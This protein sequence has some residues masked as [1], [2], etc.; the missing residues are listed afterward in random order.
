MSS[1]KIDFFAKIKYAIH[2]KD[3]Q[4]VLVDIN[5]AKIRT[6]LTLEVTSLQFQLKKPI[7]K[8]KKLELVKQTQRR[9]AQLEAM[10]DTNAK[11]IDYS[12]EGEPTHGHQLMRAE[13]LT[14]EEVSYTPG[15]LRTSR[16]ETTSRT[17]TETTE[18]KTFAAAKRE[19]DEIKGSIDST[20]DGNKVTDDGHTN[21]VGV[22]AKTLQSE[23]QIKSNMKENTVVFTKNSKGGS[24]GVKLG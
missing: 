12:L 11:D 20:M 7:A 8:H 10:A 23:G 15:I 3:T 16:P 14:S 9:V 19:I 4:N 13:N 24:I 2:K 6:I 1:P 18:L 22:Q 21:H 5:T 17:R